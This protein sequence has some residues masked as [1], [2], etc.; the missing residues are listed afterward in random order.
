MT[1]PPEADSAV[2]AVRHRLADSLLAVYIHGSAVSGGLRPHSDIDLLAVTSTAMDVEARKELAA[3]L[4]KISGCYPSDP[5]GRRPVELIVFTR[6]DLCPLP[7]PARCDFMYGEWLRPAYEAGEISGPVSDPEL[8][9]VLAQARQEAKPLIGPAAEELL[10]VV[11]RSDIHRAIADASQALLEA[12]PGD[13]RNVLLTLA[14]MW[15][16]LDTGDFVSKDV[17]AEWAAARL[18]EEHAAVL[19]DARG[20]Y[21][22]LNS[23][24]LQQCQ[25]QIAQTIQELYGRVV[26]CL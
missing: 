20:A 24:R 6:N 4:L 9:L 18:P 25:Q 23:D 13:E 26:A 3:D 17:A 11:P 12:E 22:G 5:H 7:Y 8:T 16:T 1:L 14:R 19:L 21:L 15:R 10:P 2:R